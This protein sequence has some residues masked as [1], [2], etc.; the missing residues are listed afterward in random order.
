[1]GL[2]F[3]EELGRSGHAGWCIICRSKSLEP[4]LFAKGFREIE[5]PRLVYYDRSLE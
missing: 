3:L 4:S 2:Y 1:M 5:E